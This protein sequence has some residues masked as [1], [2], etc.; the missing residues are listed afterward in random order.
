LAGGGVIASGALDA[1]V[2]FSE[3]VDVPVFSAWRRPTAFPNDHPNYLG[4]TGYG[5][6]TTVRERL[7]A[8]DTLLVVGCR[9]SEIA[10]F[11]YK[12]PSPATRWFHVDLR[13]RTKHAGLTAPQSSMAADASLFLDA[14]IRIAR[15]SLHYGDHGLVAERERF[16]KATTIPAQRPHGKGVD[17]AHVVEVLQRVL[18]A[19]AILTNDAGNFGLWPARYFKFG[20]RNVFLGPTSG[21]M[22]YGLPAAIAASLIAPER[23][24]VALCGD[25][26][27]G[28]TMNELETAVR[29]G[30]RPVVIVFDNGRYGTIAM[31]QANAHLPAVATSLGPIDFAA[32]ARACGAEGVGVSDD[33]SFEPALRAALAS[34]LPTVIHVVQDPN[35]ITPDRYEVDR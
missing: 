1:L 14:A 3:L 26:G 8:A 27:L 34:R 4:M 29:M 22:G 5:S 16:V 30:A 18:D 28:M 24:V 21:A 2:E 15:A 25:G 20:R 12:I 13:P 35:W 6:P 7:L 32:I 9:L 17:P 10:S 11:G 33:Q 19:D 31:H 23:Q